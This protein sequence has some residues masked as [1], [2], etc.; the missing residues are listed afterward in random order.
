MVL[1]APIALTGSTAARAEDAPPAADA[2][3]LHHSVAAL[4]QISPFAVV[5]CGGDYTPKSDD[6]FG[7]GGT[8]R[9]Q[10]RVSRFFAMGLGVAFREYGVGG[11]HG[12]GYFTGLSVPLLA[13]ASLP[14]SNSTAL[15][16]TVG[17]GWQQMWG[18]ADYDGKA[19]WRED[20]WDVM[21]AVGL[22]HRVAETLEIV[23]E[24]GISY[25]E[26]SYH[27]QQLIVGSLPLFGLGLRY[28]L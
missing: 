5:C 17:L 19:A 13:T 10:L 14:V 7:V 11:Q 25:G 24:I 28:S 16:L 23:W 9:Y 12:Y 4:F 8:V 27:Q 2:E 21:A 18:S 20:G 15:A 26:V 3:T 6:G 1:A 22:A